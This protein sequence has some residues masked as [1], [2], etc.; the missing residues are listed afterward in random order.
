MSDEAL[1]KLEQIEGMVAALASR[2]EGLATNQE[3]LFNLIG[4]R[5]NQRDD[6]TDRRFRGF[7][8][9]STRP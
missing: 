6:E 1:K 9:E 7:D 2:V 4:S 5:M 8:T 3:Y